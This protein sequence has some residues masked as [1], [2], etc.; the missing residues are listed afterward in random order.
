MS[1]ETYKNRMGCLDGNF[2]ELNWQN[3]A[4]ANST[5]FASV[6]ELVFRLPGAAA[7]KDEEFYLNYKEASGTKRRSQTSGWRV[8]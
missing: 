3:P 7:N 2:K 1:A 8:N 4:A 6:G 5:G